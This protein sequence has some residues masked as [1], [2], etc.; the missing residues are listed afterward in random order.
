[1]SK[2]YYKKKIVDLRLKITN[3]RE[4]KKRDNA[5]YASLI[6]NASSP[7]SKASYKKSKISKAEYHDRNIASYKREL[8]NTKEAL[9]RSKS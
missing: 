5:S 1:M 3:E 7:S 9:R 8:E 6:K 2:E 4:A